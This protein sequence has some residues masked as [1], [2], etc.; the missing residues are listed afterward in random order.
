MMLLTEYLMV[1]MYALR[2][3]VRSRHT[4]SAGPPSFAIGSKTLPLPR[5]FQSTR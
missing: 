4:W 5:L 3:R 2:M 1:V